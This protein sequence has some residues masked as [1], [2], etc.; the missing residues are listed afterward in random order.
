[1]HFKTKERLANRSFDGEVV[2]FKIL[3]P[4]LNIHAILTFLLNVLR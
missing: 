1:M 4:D 2:N 3:W